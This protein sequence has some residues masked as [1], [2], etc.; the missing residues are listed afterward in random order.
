M[1]QVTLLGLGNILLSDEGVGVW[2]VREVAR[3]FRLPA[4]VEVVDGGTAGLDLLPYVEDREHLLVVDA[5]QFQRE[6]GFVGWLEGEE[7]LAGGGAQASLHHL[8]LREVLGAALLL[9]RAPREV[10]LLGVQPHSLA[11][12][13]GLSPCLQ[14]RL[15]AVVAEIISRLRAWGYPPLGPAEPEG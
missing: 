5:V 15:P 2:A 13:V 4:A 11:T 8:G 3:R 12:G 9:D 14:A 10:L 7:V 1:G 6:P